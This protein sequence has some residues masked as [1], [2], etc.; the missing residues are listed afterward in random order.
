MICTF[1]LGSFWKGAFGLGWL[2]GLGAFGLGGFLFG[3]LLVGG[4]LG[5]GLM[6]GGL[7]ERGLWGSR[8]LD[9]CPN[10]R[11]D[12]TARFST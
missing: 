7:L 11:L 5:G 3:G 4:L 1:G 8:S 6:G 12:T 10:P 9:K 2:L